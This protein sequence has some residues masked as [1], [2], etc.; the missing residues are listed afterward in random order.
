MDGSDAVLIPINPQE[1]RPQLLRQLAHHCLVG[2]RRQR[3]G[4]NSAKPATTASRRGTSS[5]TV[6]FSRRPWLF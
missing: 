1:G 6:W 2:S 3:V 5:V 4:Q